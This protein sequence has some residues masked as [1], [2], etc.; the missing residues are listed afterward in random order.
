MCHR[1]RPPLGQSDLYHSFFCGC[2]RYWSLGW[3]RWERSGA[4]RFFHHL[5]CLFAGGRR[6]ADRLWVTPA[7]TQP[8]PLGRAFFA[9]TSGGGGHRVSPGTTTGG[10]SS[11]D[12][13]P[14]SVPVTAV[15]R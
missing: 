10:C 8:P 7:T 12:R 14:S 3:A 6:P 9:T 2:R 1:V 11:H 15:D 4:E 5:C 13:E